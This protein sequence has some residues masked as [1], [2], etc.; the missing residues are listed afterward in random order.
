MYSHIKRSSGKNNTLYNPRNLKSALPLI[1][2]KTN[3]NEDIANESIN[4]HPNG[5]KIEE[6]SKGKI[7]IENEPTEERI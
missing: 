3:K 4:W 7:Y 6:K 1:A 5:P 2:N